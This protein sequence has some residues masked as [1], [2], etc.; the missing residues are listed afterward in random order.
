MTI[1]SLAAAAALSLVATAAYAGDPSGL[2]ASEPNDEGNY[3]VVTIGPCGG[4]L[5]GV[6]TDARTADGSSNA[7]YQH[8]G[9][10]IITGMEPDGENK[11]DSGEIW[12]PDEDKT[13]SSN[14]EL[15]GNV[16]RVEGCVLFICRGQDWTRVN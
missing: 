11:W 2:W 1:R 5:C 14:M 4:K 3:I 15:Q 8:L 9:R 10:D 6:I 13:Y 16:L 7:D 12:A